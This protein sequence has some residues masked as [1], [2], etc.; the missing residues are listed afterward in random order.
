[1]AIVD[2]LECRLGPGPHGRNETVIAGDAQQPGRAWK[3]DF[4]LLRARSRRGLHTCIIG[5]QPEKSTPYPYPLQRIAHARV[6]RKPRDPVLA[7]GQPGARP[8]I[9]T[10]GIA[11]P[12]KDS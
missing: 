12:R 2:R 7:I 6:G 10:S 5:P 3:Q 8:R 9:N 11:P 4:A 1:M